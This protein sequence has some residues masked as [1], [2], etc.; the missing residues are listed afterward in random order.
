MLHSVALNKPGTQ[1]NSITRLE[2]S[3]TADLMM[4][5]HIEYV[6]PEMLRQRLID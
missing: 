2:A 1:E 3:E 6:M 4:C 5:Y